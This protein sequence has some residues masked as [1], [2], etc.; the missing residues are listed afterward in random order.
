[1]SD[2]Q[3]PFLYDNKGLV[4]SSDVSLKHS[5]NKPKILNNIRTL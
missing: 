1:M 3:S 2:L 4:K 5:N